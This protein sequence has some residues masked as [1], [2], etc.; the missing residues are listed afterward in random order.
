MEVRAVS[1]VSRLS[2]KS[3]RQTTRHS[4]ASSRRWKYLTH[5]THSLTAH[6]YHS[7]WQTNI[8]MN[9]IITNLTHS[10]QPGLTYPHQP[11]LTLTNS[12][13]HSLTLAHPYLSGHNGE[14]GE[15]LDQRPGARSRMR[16]RLLRESLEEEARELKSTFQHRNLEVQILS[17][18]NIPQFIWK[19]VKVGLG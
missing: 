12:H 7:L 19:V 10:H 5:T 11:S 17:L 16:K 8:T 4:S 18:P 3:N 2:A 15:T 1:R 6:K 13:P 9:L 14:D